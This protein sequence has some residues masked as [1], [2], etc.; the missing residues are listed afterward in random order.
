MRLDKPHGIKNWYDIRT[1]GAKSLT[2]K[3]KVVSIYR[4]NGKYWA[5]LPFEIEVANKA[6]TGNKTAVDIN[7]GHFNYTDG[8]INVLPKQLNYLYQRIKYY[9][10]SLSKKRI[11][12][13][14]QAMQS[15]NY[16]KTKA[17]LQR[18]YRKVANIQRDL[19]QKF[20]TKLVT[21]YDKIAIEDLQ[22]KQMQMNH[23]ASKGLQR[24]LFSYFRQV[25]TYKCEWYGKDLL[26]ADKY[27][28]ST[29]RCSRCGYVKTGDDKIGLAGNQKH[30]TKHNEYICYECGNVMDRDINAVYNLLALI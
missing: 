1:S 15:H 25:L 14:K 27:Y 13:G 20:T 16:V 22:V 7:V 3:L 2:G 23:V 6:K 26:I 17:K 10:K 19:I 12:N 30:N 4:E 28:P 11:V 18:D 29:Q 21:N 5:S 9:Q 24:S 8:Q